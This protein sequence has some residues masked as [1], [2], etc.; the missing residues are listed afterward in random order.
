MQS[1]GYGDKERYMYRIK[2]V[3]V[4]TT[5]FGGEKGIRTPGTLRYAGFQDRCNR[6][7][8]HL[9][10]NDDAKLDAFLITCNSLVDFF[11]KKWIL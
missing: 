10:L 8:C 4:K 6:P 1:E 5:T 11:F 7:L 9:S 2:K 3:A